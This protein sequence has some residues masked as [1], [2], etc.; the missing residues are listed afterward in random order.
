MGYLLLIS[1]WSS[2][3]TKIR[4]YSTYQSVRTQFYHAHQTSQVE[5][6]HLSLCV[7]HLMVKHVDSLMMFYQF[8]QLVLVL[9]SCKSKQQKNLSKHLLLSHKMCKNLLLVQI[10]LCVL[11]THKVFVA[12]RQSYHLESLQSLEYQSVNYVLVL[13]ILNLVQVTLTHQL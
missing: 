11:L 4:T 13:V 2:T 8:N 10:Q 6:W 5:L 7:L 9:Q 3:T 12:F 1:Q